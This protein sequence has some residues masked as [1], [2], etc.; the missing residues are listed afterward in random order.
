MNQ[1]GT[2]LVVFPARTSAAEDT[3]YAHGLFHWHL[4]QPGIVGGDMEVLLQYEALSAPGQTSSVEKAFI[5]EF[6]ASVRGRWVE[7]ALF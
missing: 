5:L 2:S 7:T 3:R 6:C 4:R 1:G